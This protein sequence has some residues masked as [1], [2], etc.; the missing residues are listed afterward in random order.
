MARL[1]DVCR[2]T[3][4]LDHGLA[5]ARRNALS[6]FIDDHDCEVGVERHARTVSVSKPGGV[7]MMRLSQ[8]ASSTI[9]AS[10]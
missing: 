3:K 6:F 2:Q 4:R 5:R 9:A 10:S 8:D 7:K 1:R